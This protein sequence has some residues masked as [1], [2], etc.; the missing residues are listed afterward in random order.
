MRL[1]FDREAMTA[2]LLT[3]HLLICIA[4]VAVILLQKSEGGALGIGGGGG[5]G[6][7]GAMGGILSNRAAGN[8]LTHVTAG[9]AVAFFATSLTL[10][11][12]AGDR[13]DG[14][15]DLMKKETAPAGEAGKPKPAA[16]EAGKGQGGNGSGSGKPKAPVAD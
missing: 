14:G 13:G 6:G 10:A 11:L 3:L 1:F 15:E 2:I 4:M 7:G 5:G 8:L 12:L 9:L 16:P